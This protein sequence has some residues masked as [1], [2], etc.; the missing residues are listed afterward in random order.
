MPKLPDPDEMNDKRAAWVSSAVESF[1]RHTG[2][3]IK[4]DGEFE[5]I[6]D[7]LADIG[8]YCDQQGLDLTCALQRAAFH[9]FEETDGQGDQFRDY[10]EGRK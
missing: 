6:G 8:H 2:Q 4:D 7:L 9:Y 1:I 10:T 3:S 5:I